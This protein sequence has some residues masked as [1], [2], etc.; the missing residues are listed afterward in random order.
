MLC[1]LIRASCTYI[2]SEV[3][4]ELNGSWLPLCC[5]SL[6]SA[7]G[8]VVKTE[9]PS[10]SGQHGGLCGGYRFSLNS[11]FLKH[12][13]KHRNWRTKEIN[14]KQQQMANKQTMIPLCSGHSNCFL[15]VIRVRAVHTKRWKWHTSIYLN[16]KKNL[17]L[18]Q[19]QRPAARELFYTVLLS[20]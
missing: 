4:V 11:V 17:L 2:S 7:Y 16:S 18:S 19:N 13:D 14:K 10:G 1:W 6:V 8:G 20:A 12:I 15:L 9:R 5:Q 3:S